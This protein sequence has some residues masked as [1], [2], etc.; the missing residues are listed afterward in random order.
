MKDI[1]I[2][3][4]RLAVADAGEPIDGTI[5]TLH[6]GRGIGDH[7]S[8]FAAFSSLTDRYRVISFDMRGHGDSSLEGPLTFD[9]LADDVEGLRQE[10]VGGPIILIGGSFGGMIALNYAVRHH[11]GLSH[12]VLRGTAP[13]YHHEDSAM[14]EF[15]ARSGKA[16]MIS[17]DMMRRM[18][19]GEIRDENE[20]RL[21]LFAMAPM[22]SDT[23]DPD[24]VLESAR[25]APIH[26]DTHN[27]LFKD[28]RT[29]DLRSKLSEVTCPALIICGS[30]DWI[31]PVDQSQL[32]AELIPNSELMVV[33]GANHAVHKQAA[34][35]VLAKVRDFTC[36]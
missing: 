25:T 1:Y 34:G 31:C 28:G 29:Y 10:L 16:P 19:A 35:Q 3:D 21:I 30:D 12:L 20:R 27:A 36:A 18:F 32:M 23:F 11:A 6:G 13:S 8:D 14:R 26:N 9:Q 22:Y 7:Q 17:K 15:F 33:E 2:N 4:A 5:I 24:E